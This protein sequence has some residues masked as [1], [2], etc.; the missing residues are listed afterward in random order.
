MASRTLG[1]ASS[2]SVSSPARTY[3]ALDADLQRLGELPGGSRPT[4]RRSPRSI[5][6]RYGFDTPARSAS[7]RT[8]M[9]ATSRWALMKSPSSARRSSS[10]WRDVVGCHRRRSITRRRLV[11]IVRLLAPV[12][13][14][15]LLAQVVELGEQLLA[16]VGDVAA[17]RRRAPRPA[18]RRSSSSSSSRRPNPWR[19]TAGRARSASGCVAEVVGRPRRAVGR[20]R[21]G[22]RRGRGAARRSARGAPA[23]PAA[24]QLGTGE[25][26]AAL[27]HAPHV[28]DGVV[29][30][31]AARA[32]APGAPPGR[33]RTSRRA[34]HSTPPETAAARRPRR[35]ARPP[36]WSSAGSPLT[37]IRHV[38][39][40]SANVGPYRAPGG[41][42]HI[43]DRRAG[44]LVTQPVPAASRAEA[45]MRTICHAA[46]VTRR[47]HPGGAQGRRLQHWRCRSTCSACATACRRGTCCG[48]GRARP[49]RR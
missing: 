14:D 36:S 34:A 3:S 49:I 29:E 2:S 46:S 1:A 8:D 6:D 10:S 4:G 26:G 47:S 17:R 37:Q 7:R 33:G 30:L 21:A 5:C 48:A 19:R 15:E 44:Q 23:V 41:A 32:A 24:G 18:R 22:D 20:R 39:R 25:V 27:G 16:L 13:P 12:A 42:E 40:T 28:R 31:P 38:A 11:G 43:A 35:S 45:N 9:L